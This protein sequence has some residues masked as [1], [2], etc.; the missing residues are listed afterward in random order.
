MSANKLKQLTQEQMQNIQ[1]V[2][3]ELSEAATSLDPERIKEAREN[4]KKEFGS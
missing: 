1:D 3:G 4:F 2:L